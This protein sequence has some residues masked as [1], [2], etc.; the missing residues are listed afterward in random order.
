MPNAAKASTSHALGR[1]KLCPS[2]ILMALASIK[3]RGPATS[4]GP[5][6]SRLMCH[7]Y[8][9]IADK[10]LRALGHPPFVSPLAPILVFLS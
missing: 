4:G 2:E 7:K 3:A 5:P 1:A 6:C 8:N 9:I 10:S